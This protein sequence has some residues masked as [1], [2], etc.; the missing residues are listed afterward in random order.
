[1]SSPFL[2]TAPGYDEELRNSVFFE[3]GL[4]ATSIC[5]AVGAA[6]AVAML[7]G[8]DE[9]GIAPRAGTP[10]SIGAGLLGGNRTRGAAERGP[11]RRAGPPRR[12]AGAP[13]RR[14]GPR[15]PPPP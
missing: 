11:R 14:R 15:H 3:R 7:Q 4:H 6:V 12:G 2:I 9:A 10:A 1:M 5:G 8:Q 13:A